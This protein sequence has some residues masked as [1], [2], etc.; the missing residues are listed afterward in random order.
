MAYLVDIG[1]GSG[2]SCQNAPLLCSATNLATSLSSPRPALSFLNL[3][4][5][6]RRFEKWTY[7]KPGGGGKLT[8]SDTNAAA[9]NVLPNKKMQ[10]ICNATDDVG[11]GGDCDDD[12]VGDYDGA[13]GGR[14]GKS[15]LTEC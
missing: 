8:S 1:S 12:D 13:G 14:A 9:L 11:Y 5:C 10:T 7:L 3:K 2:D 15:L 6:E 4:G